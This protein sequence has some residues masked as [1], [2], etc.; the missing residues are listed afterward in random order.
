VAIPTDYAERVYA[1]VLGKLIGVYLGRPIETWSFERI[2]E[3]VGDVDRY[4]NYL[5]G[6]PLVVADDDITGTFTF[7]RTLED[8]GYSRDITSEQVGNN[9]LN[10]AIERKSI[11]AWGGVGNMTEHT[12][13]SRLKEGIKAP[14]SGSIA[15][16]GKVI[17]E[18]IGA[19]IFIDGWGMVAPGD[20]EFAADLAKRAGS[21]SHDGEA[22]YG[23]QVIAAM[24]SQAFVE[25]DINK[26]LDTGA[27]VIPADSVIAR[28]IHDVREW[29]AKIPDWREAHKQIVANYGYDKYI[30]VCHM[31]PNHALIIHALLYGEGDFNKSELIVNTNAWDTDCNAANVGC[32]LGVRGGLATFDGSYDWRGPVADRLYLSTADGGRG[33]SDAVTEAVHVVNAG[34]ALQGEAPIAPKDGARFHFSFP[35]SVQGFEADPDG[36]PATIANEHAQLVIRAENATAEQPAR[37]LTPTFIPAESLEP[38]GFIS[39][40]LFASPTLY[41]TQT[42]TAVVAGHADNSA[43]VEASL[44][45][46]YYDGNDAYALLSG[47]RVT[48]APGEQ[49]TLEWQIPDLGGLTIQAV[50]IEVIGTGAAVLDRLGWDGMPSVRFTKPADANGVLWRRGWI[51]GVD[52]FDRWWRDPF[53]IVKNEDRGL[54]SQ[55]TRE[56][57]DYHAEAEITPSLAKF[58]GLG[59][60]VQGMRRYYAIL[61]GKDNV[62]RLVKM[63]DTE[64]VLAEAPFDWEFFTPYT[65]L[66]DVNG[67]EITGSVA[68]GPTL[69]AT[70]SG[71]R[72]TG[73]SVGLVIENGTLICESV[74]VRG[75]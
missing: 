15:T 31:V 47:S 39:Y 6:G 23:A 8:E 2:A 9:W 11:F 73:G 61:L 66:L 25:H 3:E 17:A 75:L 60:R 33:I 62:V 12:A 51:D 7:L 26:L 4:L 44:V 46:R 22:V 63:D 71:S 65:L 1:G 50:G 41:P 18:Q 49:M 43:P 56:W 69:T 32:I 42:V 19:Q 10:Y 70:D 24:V 35:G 53:R 74:S 64:T 21:V 38:A 54:I 55:G 68:G 45:I 72:L 13:Y 20:P 30:G 37:A 27:S 48:L 34:R 16:N 67:A 14:D 5:H 59:A 58:A 57:R 40:G 36:T 52:H 28:V 29:H